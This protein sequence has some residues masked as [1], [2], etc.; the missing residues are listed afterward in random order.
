MFRSSV[1]VMS[2]RDAS[3][4]RRGASEPLTRSV[5]G[6]KVCKDDYHSDA[7]FRDDLRPPRHSLYLIHL[8]LPGVVQ[9]SAR[10]RGGHGGRGTRT[11]RLG[12][13]YRGLAA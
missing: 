8:D 6:L 5:S 7:A 4:I 12:R 3:L 2:K 11:E 10:S 13:R 9:F 1:V